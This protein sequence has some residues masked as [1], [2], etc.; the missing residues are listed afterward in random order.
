MMFFNKDSLKYYLLQVFSMIC[1][2][3]YHFLNRYEKQHI[4]HNRYIFTPLKFQKGKSEIKNFVGSISDV[5]NF[6]G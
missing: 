6:A 5:Q 2:S 4:K 3:S 1:T